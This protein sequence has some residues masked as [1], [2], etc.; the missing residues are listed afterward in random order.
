MDLT[1]GPIVSQILKFAIPLLCSS[2]VQQLYNTVDL[3]YVGRFLGKNAS[4][5]VG[6]SSMMVTCLVGLFGGL[7]VG[8]SV[9]VSRYFGAKDRQQVKNTIH[10]A[11]ALSLISG[12]LIMLI[13][14]AFAPTFIRLIKTPV[15][16]QAEAVTY[17]RI[18][19]CSILFV[20]SYNMASGIIRAMGDT[21]SPL[22]FQIV[23]GL[24]NVVMDA[25]FIFEFE[26][27]VDGVAW[28]TWFSQ[29]IAAFMA[30]RYLFKN[31]DSDIKLFP[32]DIKIHG[33][34]LKPILKVG[35]PAGCQTLVI[36]LS[37]VVAQSHIN[38]L[39]TDAIAAF[40]AYF[41]I[42]LPIYMPIVAVGQATTTFVSQNLGA[43]QF[44]RASK[45]TKTCL[46]LG[47][48]ITIVTSMAM[49]LIGKYAFG[50]FYKE[51]S[52]IETGLRI[53]ATTFPFYC[54][55]VVLEVFGDAMKG[56]GKANVPMTVIL[57]N[58]CVL[59]SILLYILV[60]MYP[61]VKAV[62]VTYP[63]TWFTTALGMVVYYATGKWKT[64]K[65]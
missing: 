60:P 41:K 12:I 44:D 42:E 45:G 16:I 62:A 56:A 18:Y 40:T 13:G 35:I 43:K 50:L 17:L 6:A 11:A 10:T 1:K 21:R 2:L 30:V 4:A 20:V 3:L 7:S 15:D 19:F 14:W 55:Y 39:G 5:A 38:S 27:G 58:I 9:V 24:T 31:V 49:L 63:V 61:D 57:A 25:V 29:G 32:R 8:A 34:I 51:A 48:G 37:N 46:L 65:L 22:M 36:A 26:R 54:L 23:G 28:A 47:L 59:R 53:I 33:D 52:V 64:D